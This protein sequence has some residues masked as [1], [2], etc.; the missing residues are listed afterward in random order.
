ML[1]SILGDGGPIRTPAWTPAQLPGISG[2]WEGDSGASG[3]GASAAWVDKLTSLTV[4]AT[5]GVGPAYSATAMNNLPGFVYDGSASQTLGNAVTNLAAAGAARW[6]LVVC[7][8]NSADT[9]HNGFPFSFRRA[10]PTF[11][12]LLGWLGAQ[13]F[14]FDGTNAQTIT[15]PPSQQPIVGEWYSSGAGSTAL[16]GFIN[17]APVQGLSGTVVASDTGTAG[18][19]IGSCQ[20]TSGSSFVGPICSVITG[21]GT[22][23]AS[24]VA[25]VRRYAAAKWL[26]PGCQ[27]F[28]DSVA[29]YCK[30]VNTSGLLWKYMSSPSCNGTLR[31]LVPN[32]TTSLVVGLYRDFDSVGS[33]VDGTTAVYVDGVY[34]TGWLTAAL[35]A[36]TKTLTLD[37]AAH[38]V[39][40]WTAFQQDGPTGQYITSVSGTGISIPSTPPA[41]S[42]RIVF[43]GDSIVTGAK[44]S[45]AATKSFFGI[46]RAAYSGRLTSVSFGN[47]SLSQDVG[48]GT[49]GQ[50]NGY[51]SVAALSAALVA[52]CQEGNPGTKI[53]WIQMGVNDYLNNYLSPTNW[54]TQMGA[55]LDA[56]H[57][58]DASIV[59]YLMSI[60]T[61]QVEAT[62]N[63]GGFVPP[64]FRTAA[65]NVQSTRTGFVTLVS[66][67]SMANG[68]A[69]WFVDPVHFNDTGHAGIA[70]NMRAVLGF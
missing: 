62:T 30:V 44:A 10:Q 26:V 4:T 53:L 68:G 6:L 19:D 51:G 64:D 34:N 18:F 58:A 31:V 24:D 67:L 22:L 43:Y 50:N 39:D 57:A 48:S 7:M 2:W 69:G 9:I 46:M 40:L 66:G 56:V 45:V 3:A 42:K 54:A 49:A 11:G 33:G 61:T 1:L 36:D 65:A 5:T 25:K 47:R 27:V 70:T 16:S 41:T 12:A 17:G 13:Y 28:N 59:I 8:P 60:F 15:H 38:T 32:G 37:G 52:A 20:Y 23:S 63:G 29:Q 35:G 55:V 14:F 21:T